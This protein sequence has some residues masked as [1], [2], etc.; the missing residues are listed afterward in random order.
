MAKI[1]ILG[2]GGLARETAILA[3]ICGHE[4]ACFLDEDPER[5]GVRLNGIPVVGLE[6]SGSLDGVVGAIGNPQNRANAIIKAENLGFDF[7]S[8]IHP[9]VHIADT[10]QIGNGVVIC[11]GCVI[12]TNICV[13]D[14]VFINLNC[15]IGHDSVLEEFATLT[16]G[17]HISGYV[18]I[19]KRAF[20]G[21]GAVIIDG[22][23]RQHLKIGNDV[24][25]G[26]SA[27]VTKPVDSGTVVG[28]PAHRL[29]R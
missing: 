24:V 15:T 4:V 18:H 19:G 7:V 16:P 10:N 13:R 25:I 3:D 20:V 14:H 2:S 27:C 21:T 12:T 1:A 29:E 8:L 28:V 17:V 23:W 6:E 22:S 26:A 11:S 5:S 9:T